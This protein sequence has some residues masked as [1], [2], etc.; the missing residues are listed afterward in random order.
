MWPNAQ[1]ALTARDP[2]GRANDGEGDACGAGGRKPARTC[3]WASLVTGFADVRSPPRGS[4]IRCATSLTIS[5][6]THEA[7]TLGAKECP[8]IVEG[9][10]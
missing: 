6:R 5:I 8:Q 9:C 3:P 2:T 7:Y 1:D 10:W 4:I